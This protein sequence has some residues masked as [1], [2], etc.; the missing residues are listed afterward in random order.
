[1]YI[2]VYTYIHEYIYPE[3]YSHNS[4]QHVRVRSACIMAR[5][6]VQTHRP[7]LTRAFCRS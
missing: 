6:L 1:M 5:T 7:K 4:C 3:S 2:Y